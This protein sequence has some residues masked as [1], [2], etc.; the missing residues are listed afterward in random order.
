MAR[1]Q[2]PSPD[3]V[4]SRWL[5]QTSTKELKKLFGIESK[6]A[7]S[8]S[9]YVKNVSRGALFH[10]ATTTSGSE[11][12]KQT[13]KTIQDQVKVLEKIEFFT[14]TRPVIKKDWKFKNQ[15]PD[16][17]SVVL[18]QCPKCK[19]EGAFTCKV[20][21]GKKKIP[22]KRCKGSGKETCG[23]CKD[24]KQVTMIMT[25]RDESGN[26]NEKR[27]QVQ[28]PRCFGV[29]S[30]SC[31]DCSGLGEIACPNCRG[32][33]EPCKD[34]AGHGNIVTYDLVTVPFK[35]E[36]S[37]KDLFFASKNF[38]WIL[39]DKNLS[40]TLQETDSHAIL[41]LS[42]LNEETI[43]DYFGV[44]KLEKSIEDP[45]KDCRK[46]FEKLQKE[47]NKKKSD[48]KPKF[49]I[50]LYFIQVLHVETGK[51]KKFDLLSI[52]SKHRFVVLKQ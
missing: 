44:P 50:K 27:I 30:I 51:K 24:K 13:V 7:I 32:R 3:D 4:F 46:T 43:K 39:K 1:L 20:C 5:Q 10:F 36:A 8:G 19:G 33:P 18:K 2:A 52:G 21:G 35:T 23:T 26:K 37:E 49:P 34:C 31:K 6:E 41:D 47:F 25:V 14:L 15:V 11:M 38:N 45:M 22:C 48:Q 28:C 16:A 17:N 40:K 29:G 42:K 9:E 12:Q